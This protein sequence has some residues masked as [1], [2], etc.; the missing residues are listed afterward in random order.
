LLIEVDGDDL[1]PLY[2][3]TLKRL[4][5]E[6]KI[7]G[8]RAG[9]VP[10]AVLESRLGEAA[11]KEEVL[12]DALPLLYAKAAQSES[13]RAI[14]YPD[15]EVTEYSQGNSLS[16]TA[17][18]EVRPEIT[19]PEYKGIEVQ[20]PSA[21]P[22]EEEIDDQ[23]E[24]LRER[25]ATL[26]TIGRPSASGDFA[27]IDLRATRHTE[28]IE[29]A[30][31]EGLL[32]EIGSQ[33]LVPELDKEL[34]G[35]RPGD[36]LKFNGILPESFGPPHG[37]EEVTYQVIVKEVQSRKLPQLD[38]EF[39]KTASQFDA[40]DELR[41]EIAERL[42]KIKEGQSDLEVR[43]LIVQDLLDRTQVDLPS[44]MV[45]AETES[46]L[47]RLVR[48]LERAQI[49]LEN[50]LEA[51]EKTEEELVEAYKASAEKAVAAELIL[52]AVA[53]AEG[54]EVTGEDMETEIVSIAEQIDKDPVELAKELEESGRVG[55]LA[56]DILKRKTLEILVKEAK[57]K[58]ES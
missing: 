15:I 48:D 41:K 1:K 35:K 30:R 10:K 13:L 46:R 14:T 25:Y 2:E 12:K 37:G 33:A 56:G 20:K 17:V 26:E 29:Q 23:I 49:P 34:E 42:E 47:A 40:L 24:R 38:D 50:Y 32:Y 8:F 11:I 43:N 9:K 22:T 55:V 53:E 28:E 39:A 3:T 58:S 19:L 7:P 18:V 36:I 5:R 57:I 21:R 27:T 51:N 31:A 6:L 44:S 16:F 52:D 54:L 4:S 45:A